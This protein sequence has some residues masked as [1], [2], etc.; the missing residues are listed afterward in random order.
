MEIN[1]ASFLL[2]VQSYWKSAKYQS[3]SGHN[4]ALNSWSTVKIDSRPETISTWY[5]LSKNLLHTSLEYILN[6]AYVSHNIYCLLFLKKMCKI[7]LFPSLKISERQLLCRWS[8][9]KHVFISGVLTWALVLFKNNSMVVP[10]D[11]TYQNLRIKVV[12]IPS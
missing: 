12:F 7:I 8:F 4:F 10:N 5:I 11:W 2:A 9:F 1:C 6:H 3:V